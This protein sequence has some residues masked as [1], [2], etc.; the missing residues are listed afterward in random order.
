MGLIAPQLIYEK[1]SENEVIFKPIYKA[2]EKKFED[3][4]NKH[5]DLLKLTAKFAGKKKGT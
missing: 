3:M 5:R 4:R 2:L 1:N